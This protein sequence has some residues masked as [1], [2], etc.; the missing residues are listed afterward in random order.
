VHRCGLGAWDAARGDGDSE[1]ES[2]AES[3]A[4]DPGEASE[5]EKMHSDSGRDRRWLGGGLPTSE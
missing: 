5:S 1:A 4:E 3:G 2:G